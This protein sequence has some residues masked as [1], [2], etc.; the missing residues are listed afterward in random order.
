MSKK[1][2]KC[3]K[4]LYSRKNWDG[5]YS[6]KVKVKLGQSYA[7]DIHRCKNPGGIV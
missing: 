5:S 4:K 6:I 7:F 2:P 1:C 3:G